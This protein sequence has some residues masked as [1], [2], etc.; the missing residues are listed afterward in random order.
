MAV[1]PDSIE[2]GRCYLTRDSRLRRVTGIRENGEVGY[3][4]RT[5]PANPKKT[6]RSGALRPDIFAATVE[7]EVACDWTPETEVQA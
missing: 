2:V 6:W 1:P 3:K 7:R 5:F 4:Y